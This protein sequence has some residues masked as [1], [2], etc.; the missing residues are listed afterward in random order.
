MWD[1]GAWKCSVGLSVI[2]MTGGTVHHLSL[3]LALSFSRNKHTFVNQSFVLYRRVW[4]VS[5]HVL[6][7]YMRTSFLGRLPCG[8]DLYLW[9]F[10]YLGHPV[11]F[12][13]SI[14]YWLDCK[15]LSPN[16][17]IWTIF[18]LEE[19]SIKIGYSTPSLNHSIIPGLEKILQKNRH[20]WFC[21]GIWWTSEYLNF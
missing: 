13:K 6:S 15:F 16:S 2:Q 5:L 17:F 12:A 4:A 8:R 18:F 7:D 11:L 21:F 14:F 1:N 3:A 19:N 10:R 20:L 9:V